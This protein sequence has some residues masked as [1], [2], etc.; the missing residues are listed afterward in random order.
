MTDTAGTTGTT[1]GHGKAMAW[2]YARPVGSYW[3]NSAFSRLYRMVLC[4]AKFQYPQD[5]IR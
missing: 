1:D 2:K 5:R 4:H 3:T